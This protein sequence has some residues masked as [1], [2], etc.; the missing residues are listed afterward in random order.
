MNIYF[1]MLLSVFLLSIAIINVWLQKMTI[2]AYAA[3]CALLVIATLPITLLSYMQYGFFSI[4]VAV[5]LFGL[6]S[7]RNTRPQNICMGLTGCVLTVMID[8]F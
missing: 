8:I 4:L 5:C 1:E 7:Y 3:L 2:K 6:I